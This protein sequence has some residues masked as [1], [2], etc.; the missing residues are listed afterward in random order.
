M[1]LS[2][3]LSHAGWLHEHARTSPSVIDDKGDGRQRRCSP[4]DKA[5]GLYGAESG[6]RLRRA[7][8]G[9]GCERRSSTADARWAYAPPP[10]PDPARARLACGVRRCAAL[11]CEAPA[12]GS[13]CVRPVPSDA[14]CATKR[15]TFPLL[16][17]PPGAGID[18]PAIVASGDVRME[19]GAP[20]LDP[21]PTTWQC[22]I[23]DDDDDAC[24]QPA[25]H[26]CTSCG[27]M[28]KV[29]FCESYLCQAHLLRHHCMH[30]E[31]CARA[32]ATAA[33]LLHDVGVVLTA[34]IG[35]GTPYPALPLGRKG[36][37]ET[38][39]RARGQVPQH[40]H[41]QPQLRQSSRGRRAGVRLRSI[42][43]RKGAGLAPP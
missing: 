39:G 18:H 3:E 12:R 24:G 29:K 22:S 43:E 8:R 26:T 21:A 14:P 11:V 32:L 5:T 4:P 6:E 10:R 33:T 23:P 36:Q 2:S 1:K 34:T 15:A 7:D 27:H 25:T 40:R 17:P 20:D 9:S 35:T 28:C 13:A 37:E 31:L 19:D 30:M 16:M 38:G 41:R 42:E